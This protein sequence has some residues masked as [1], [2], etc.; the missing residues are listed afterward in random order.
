VADSSAV[1]AFDPSKMTPQQL[2][3]VAEQFSKLPPEEQ[4]RLM[5]AAQNGAAGGSP[6]L[7]ANGQTSPQAPAS[8]QQQAAASQGAAMAA[9]PEDASMK[10]RAGFDQA[11]PGATNQPLFVPSSPQGAPQ[12]RSQLI[13]S[14]TAPSGSGATGGSSATPGSTN[15][16]PLSARTDQP[17][18]RTAIDKIEV[19]V[20]RPEGWVANADKGERT[21][22]FVAS[23][24]EAARKAGCSS[25]EQ[26]EKLGELQVL[27][28][29]LAHTEKL[30]N[31]I[32]RRAPERFSEFKKLDEQLRSDRQQF[33]DQAINGLSVPLFAMHT[34]LQQGT[35]RSTA[36]GIE[37]LNKWNG[38]YADWK[39]RLDHLRQLRSSNRSENVQ[40]VLGLTSYITEQM[41]E[42]ERLPGSAYLKS[43]YERVGMAKKVS[44]V[45]EMALEFSKLEIISDNRVN[46]ALEQ[47][48]AD[49]KARA[50]L[51]PLQRRLSDK[52]DALRRNPVLARVACP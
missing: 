25:D 44:D 24:T 42:I 13:P 34:Q 18:G 33:I 47:A 20:P 7:G 46:T 40:G 50:V 28:Q 49:L 29:Q 22:A 48:D 37:T 41:Q 10:A 21:L 31:D 2:A 51:L 8:L 43:V 32:D 30:I 27:G 19:P 16:L 12:T 52:I 1:P 4:E 17:A 26:T 39:E 15:S 23:R 38:T 5:K 36:E 9:L 14:T 35:L 6:A 11:L 3:D 45:T